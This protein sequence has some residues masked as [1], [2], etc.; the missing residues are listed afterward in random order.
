[1]VSQRGSSHRC[2]QEVPAASAHKIAPLVIPQVK[3][4]PLPET[5]SGLGPLGLDEATV[6]LESLVEETHRVLVRDGFL[7][8]G[9]LLTGGGL[10]PSNLSLA[11]DAAMRLEHNSGGELTCEPAIPS[12]DLVD[13]ALEELQRGLA[14]IDTSLSLSPDELPLAR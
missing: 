4:P 2:A 8:P 7:D 1:M 10:F 3:V 12:L 9:D 14:E 11:Q 6:A 13:K 5:I